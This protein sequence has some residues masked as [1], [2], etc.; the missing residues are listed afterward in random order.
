VTEMTQTKIR[1]DKFRVFISHSYKHGHRSAQALSDGLRQKGVQILGRNPPPG[2]ELKGF[3][4]EAITQANLMIVLIFPGD[5][6]RSWIQYEIRLM[7]QT[8]WEKSARIVVIAPATGAIPNALRNR[9]FVTFFSHDEARLKLWSKP[10]A[11]D[12]FVNL[13]LD[14]STAEHRRPEISDREVRDWRNQVVHVRGDKW[15]DPQLKTRIR[16]RLEQDLVKMVEEDEGEVPDSEWV[17]DRAVLALSIGDAA[18]TRKYHELLEK[19]YRLA[20][21][22]PEAELRGETL[23]CRG[24]VALGVGDG[25]EAV[26]CF[27]PA[28]QL[29]RQLYG[30]NHPSTV[31]TIFSL[32]LAEERC[33]RRDEALRRF[34]EAL[35]LS[36]E[37]LGDHHPQTAAIAYNLA[38]LVADLG[39]AG[40][41]ID[42]LKFAEDAYRHVRPADSEELAAIR[43][44]LDVL[45]A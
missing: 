32:A 24:M 10:Q 20:A 35:Q 25:E 9:D 36:R 42:L 43:R 44:R 1:D 21:Q 3:F 7:L 12:A 16:A 33:G 15:I 26:K 31:A 23:F 39:D 30:K 8:C 14:S 19:T 27:L 11:C 22:S 6:E 5:E 13:L 2:V 4:A 41:A 28:V 45:E 29:N 40:Q 38:T 37:S 17:L 18:L 34:T